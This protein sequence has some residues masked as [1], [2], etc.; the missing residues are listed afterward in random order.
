[1]LCFHKNV[2]GSIWQTVLRIWLTVGSVFILFMEVATPNF[3][4]TFDLRPNRLFIEYLVHPREVFTML[5]N[6]HLWAVIC[7]IGIAMI[8]LIIY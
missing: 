5:I 1:M 3:I 8:S 4:E 7:G 2:L 6:G